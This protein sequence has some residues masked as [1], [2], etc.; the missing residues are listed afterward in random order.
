[1]IQ[2]HHR[3]AWGGGGGGGE[4][5][6]QPDEDGKFICRDRGWCNSGLLRLNMTHHSFSMF[7]VLEYVFGS[8]LSLVIN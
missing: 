7:I 1:M 6:G 8:Y 5:A 4:A 2:T 3:H